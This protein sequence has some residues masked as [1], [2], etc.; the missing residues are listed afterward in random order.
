MKIQKKEI[1]DIIKKILDFNKQQ[2]G[3]GYSLYRE[4]EVTK[5]YITIYWIQSSY[6]TELID[7]LLN[8]ITYCI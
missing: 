2:N 5:K 8:P 4:K 7:T 6:K 3:K 1:V